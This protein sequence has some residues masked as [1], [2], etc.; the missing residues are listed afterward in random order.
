MPH[1]RDGVE[2]GE[3]RGVSGYVSLTL[4]AASETDTAD[5]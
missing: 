3:M 4:S 2:D 5:C 1:V